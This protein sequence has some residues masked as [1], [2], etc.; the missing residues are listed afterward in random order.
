MQQNDT[1]KGVYMADIFGRGLAACTVLGIDP[2]TVIG[3]RS[4]TLE[5]HHKVKD[6]GISVET[7]DYIGV[8][9]GDFDKCY[10]KSTDIRVMNEMYKDGLKKTYISQILDV[11]TNIINAFIR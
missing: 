9:I 11:S 4:I 6:V 7:D 5:K 2:D 8:L 1:V 10:K 3:V